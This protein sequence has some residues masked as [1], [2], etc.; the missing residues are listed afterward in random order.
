MTPRVAV[1]IVAFRNLDDIER[2]MAALSNS[3]YAAF[4]VVICENG[5]AAAYAALS[6]ALAAELPGGQAVKTIEAPGNVGFAGGVNLCLEASDSADA[7]WILNPDTQPDPEALGALVTRLLAGDCDA[8]GSTLYGP[9]DRVQSHGGR[10]RGWLSRAESLGLGSRL[11]DRIDPAAIE[12][13]QSYIVGA[14]MLVGRRFRD[15]AGF[16]REDYFLYCEEVEWCLRARAA[17]LRLGFAPE[18]LIRH[19]QGSTTG[20]GPDARRRPRLPIYL[21]ERNRILLTRDCFAGRL[22]L[23]A[24]AAL[25]LLTLRY[26]RPGS[27]GSWRQALSGWWAGLRDERGPP[28]WLPV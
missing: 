1:C 3:T 27:L 6:A 10:W 5:G 26:L 15:L 12:R 24:V 22:P 14:S 18:A 20:A 25:G 19:A 4:D 13:R 11:S 21:T 2:C 16:M 23:V 17:G 7:W 28:S 8:V 9:A